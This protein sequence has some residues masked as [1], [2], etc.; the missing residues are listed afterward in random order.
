MQVTE[1]T[2]DVPFRQEEYGRVSLCYCYKLLDSFAAAVRA[3]NPALLGVDEGHPLTNFN[4]RRHK[5]RRPTLMH[6]FCG[7]GFYFFLQGVAELGVLANSRAR[8][9]A[10]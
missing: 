8:C 9:R 7:Q 5:R 2:G 4:L 3:R 10:S 1:A 6:E